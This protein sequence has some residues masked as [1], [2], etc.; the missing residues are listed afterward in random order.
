MNSIPWLT[1]LLVIPVGGAI[2]LQLVPRTSPNAAKWL[3][4]A[5]T[6]LEGAIVAGLV[7][8]FTHNP[9]GHTFA[10]P[11]GTGASAQQA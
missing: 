8:S 1:L 5:I 11:Q 6:L 3:T 7:V 4:I 2:L 9:G 10:L